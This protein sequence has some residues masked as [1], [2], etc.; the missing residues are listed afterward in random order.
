MSTE[1]KRFRGVSIKK[2]L[3]DQVEEFITDNPEYK[4]VADFIHESIRVH[5]H[6]IRQKNKKRFQHLNKGEVVRIIE[7]NKD[8]SIKTV[9]D[10]YF[11][12]PGLIYCDHCESTDCEHIQFALT[13]TDIREIIQ[14]LNKKTG[15]NIE[16]PDT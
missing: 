13:V 12:Q 16:L 3:I 2:E 4:G 8:G 7:N 15:W 1:E 6:T 5:M 10:L 9:A 11:K 14:N